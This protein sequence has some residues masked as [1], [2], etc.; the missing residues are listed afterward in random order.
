MGLAYDAMHAS[1]K[2][3]LRVWYREEEEEEEGGG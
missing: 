3:S 2:A 1:L